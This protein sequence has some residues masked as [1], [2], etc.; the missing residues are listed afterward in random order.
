MV[1][2]WIERRRRPRAR[3]R[4]LP[5]RR[6]DNGWQLGRNPSRGLIARSLGLAGVAAITA[7]ASAYLILHVPLAGQPLL[8]ALAPEL[9]PV[10]AWAL[11]LVAAADAAMVAAIVGR[12]LDRPG[13]SLQPKAGDW[14]PEALKPKRTSIRGFAVTAIA[15]V[16]LVLGGGALGLPLWA[17]VL[18]GLLPWLPVYLSEAS[19]QYQHYGAYV[20]FGALALLQLGH[21]SE[22]VVQNLQLLFSHG[23][24][25]RSRGVFGQLDLETVH[26]Y[27]NVAIWL[28]TGLLLYALG[29]QNRW[30]WVAFAVATLHSVEHIYL[31]WIYVADH[32]AYVAG[33]IA[34][35]MGK[36]GLIGS[37]LARPYLHLDYNVVEVTPFLLALWDQ[38]KSVY[39]RRRPGL[40]AAPPDK[41]V[42]ALIPA[43]G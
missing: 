30:L 9:W 5:R 15:C 31:F 8:G 43:E 1:G 41:P 29:I 13:P 39:D 26:F 33:G 38:S 28:G 37:P 20:F 35:I 42:N 24:A 3:I 36:G 19:W 22:H 12:H 16:A 14:I 4:S 2:P 23:D 11:L 25:A 17:G 7:A 21:L 18:L 40:A 10:A 34:G 32:P 27:W 6:H